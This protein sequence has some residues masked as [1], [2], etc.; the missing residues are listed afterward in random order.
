MGRNKVVDGKETGGEK[1]EK[2]MKSE[3]GMSR[4]MAGQDNVVESGFVLKK[5]RNVLIT[6]ATID[7]LF[8]KLQAFEYHLDLI[9]QQI[10]KSRKR[11][12]DSDKQ[13]MDL[14]LSL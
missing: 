5:A 2:K 10:V 9:T 1:N 12:R 3:K 14:T 7:E 6:V 4:C 8:V 13:E 11:K